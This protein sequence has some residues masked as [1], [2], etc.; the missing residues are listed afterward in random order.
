MGKAAPDYSFVR[1]GV[2]LAEWLRRL[3]G[4]DRG[5]RRSAGDALQAMNWG[6]PAVNTRIEDLDGI[7]DSVAQSERFK[8]AIRGV[9]AE[10]TID[11]VGAAILRIRGLA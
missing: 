11:P 4:D 2:P 6:Y 7:P 9:L 8:Q 1:E 10:A 5:V 3:V